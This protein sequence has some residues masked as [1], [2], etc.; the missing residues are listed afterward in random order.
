MAG[1]LATLIHQLMREDFRRI[2]PRRVRVMLI[3]AGERVLRTF[4]KSVSRKAEEQLHRLGVQVC[5]SSRVTDIGPEFIRI[6]DQVVASAVTIWATGVAASPLAKFLSN[7]LDRVGRVPVQADLTVVGQTNV[8]VIGDLAAAT[9]PDGKMLP[10]L[11]SVAQQQGSAVATY[12]KNDLERVPRRA[13]VYRDRGSMAVIGR[14]AAVAQWRK[15]H[16]SGTVAW[17]IWAFVHA[18]L[19]LDFRSRTSVLREWAWSLLTKRT[20]ALL[21]TGNRNHPDDLRID[22]ADRAPLPDRLPA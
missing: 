9:N 6:G 13:F 19:L 4:D 21:I 22:S 11:A 5:T 18:T 3:E 14:R 1:T 20:A 8:F 17:I 16:L 2:D 15:L 10:G 12:I 7:G